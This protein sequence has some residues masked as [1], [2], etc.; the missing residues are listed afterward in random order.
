MAIALVGI[1]MSPAS[2]LGSKMINCVYGTNG[3]DQSN[4]YSWRNADF[5]G[6]A[7]TTRTPNC[8]VL[9]T[10][11]RALYSAYPGG[12]AYWTSW[13]STSYQSVTKYQSGT[14]K[15]EHEITGHAKWQT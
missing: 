9:V 13:S 1:P 12:P 11:V 2:A 4:G 7:Q 5:T 3:T 6:G 15:G 10:S 8:N 14:S